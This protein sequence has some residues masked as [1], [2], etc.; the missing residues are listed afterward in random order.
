MGTKTLAIGGVEIV[1]TSCLVDKMRFP[2]FGPLSEIYMNEFL[3]DGLEDDVLI[4]L[5]CPLIRYLICL[6]RESSHMQCREA[7]KQNAF[8]ARPPESL[9]GRIK[10]SR[11]RA[12]L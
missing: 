4:Q 10:K 12:S 9:N 1:L 3:F 11:S 2:T 6:N 5:L 7:Y 8:H